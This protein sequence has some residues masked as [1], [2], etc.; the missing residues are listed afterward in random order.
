MQKLLVF[1]E[2]ETAGLI[3]AA[4]KAYGLDDTCIEWI[5]EAMGQIPL[6]ESEYVGLV[7]NQNVP[8]RKRLLR[9]LDVSSIQLLY[10][11]NPFE[12]LFDELIEDLGRLEK[13][14]LNCAPD[15]EDCALLS[16]LHG[17]RAVNLTE[18]NISDQGLKS[19]CD[20]Q[21]LE[22]L[23]LSYTNISDFGLDCLSRLIDLRELDLSL[24]MI[25]D[26]GLAK[27]STLK[28]LE[29]L[30]LS[31]TAISDEGLVHL[32]SLQKLAYLDVSETAVSEEG[33]ELLESSLPDCQIG[34]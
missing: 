20:I 33:V 28:T 24:T 32:L 2:D 7:F 31:A 4:D 18:S 26:A 12:M 27:I 1:P 11:H 6:P 16:A 13:A 8:L 3:F 25:T 17:L 15:D 10:F 19:L 30:R 23:V 21:T 29:E 22:S 34:F 5:G 9:E 14:V